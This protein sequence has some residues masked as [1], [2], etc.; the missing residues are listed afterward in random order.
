MKIVFVLP[1]WPRTPGGGYRIVYKYANEL[2]SRQHEV[3]VVHPHYMPNSPVQQI[4][5][6]KKIR[7]KLGRIRNKIFPPRTISWEWIDPR[8]KLLYVPTLDERHIPNADVVIATAWQTAEYV[9]KYPSPKGEKF[10]FIQH[11]EVWSGPKER[12]D[13]TWKS[14]LHKIVISKW[15]YDLAKQMGINEVI[16]I[17]NAIDHTFFRLIN[18]IDKR[19]PRISMMFSETE[20]KGSKDGIQALSIVKKYFPEVS[21]VFFGL[22]S[23]SS[24]IP[25]WVEYVRNPAQEYLIEKI[26]NNSSI[27]LCPSWTEGWHLPPAE[28]M[29]CGCAVV[30]TD[31]GG[32]RDYAIDEDTALLSPP[33]EP[34]KLAKNIIKLLSDNNLRIQIAERG[35]QNILKFTWEQSANM[36][37]G[38]LKKYV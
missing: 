2:V 30:S 32:V 10:Y 23:R 37:E 16:H 26:Y 12:V 15:L 1:G 20:W 13:A 7:R 33:H 25:S 5:F 8:V 21:G 11:Y 31:I 27:Y 24:I 35:R 36:L 4:N 38:F 9:E 19:L 29:S 17:P 3:I 22:G 34:E 28:A 18:P 6:Y 14:N